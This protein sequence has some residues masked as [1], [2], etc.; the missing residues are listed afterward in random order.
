MNSALSRVERP[1]RAETPQN[2]PVDNDDLEGNE[3]SYTSSPF[4]QVA[5]ASWQ[6]HGF[7]SSEGP[8]AADGIETVRRR[9]FQSSP[10]KQKAVTQ[11]NSTD[12]LSPQHVATEPTLAYRAPTRADTKVFAP[13]R[14]EVRLPQMDAERR[15]EYQRMPPSK[16]SS[17]ASVSAVSNVSSSP[18]RLATHSIRE[19]TRKLDLGKYKY[20][21]QSTAAKDK[22]NKTSSGTRSNQSKRKED[23][24]K[25]SVFAKAFEN[26]HAQMGVTERE[27]PPSSF[28]G[29]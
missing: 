16:A 9:L 1:R 15:K 3:V 4:G 5:N 14:L 13:S 20:G 11:R 23:I 24:R 22:V 17:R 7:T 28:Y 26:H 18:R 19:A 6:W 25:K 8:R 10:V 12:L 2:V 27:I 29:I 21:E